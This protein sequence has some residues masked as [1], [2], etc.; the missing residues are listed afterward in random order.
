MVCDLFANR[1]AVPACWVVTPR[2]ARERVPIPDT[3]PVIQPPCQKKKTAE[4]PQS[5][6]PTSPFLLASRYADEV[7][8]VFQYQKK[9]KP[10]ELL[11]LIRRLP[12][13]IMLRPL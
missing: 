6:C 3:L 5:S 1:L 12:A 4:I 10:V 13:S 8:G 7:S 11:M 2:P 9:L